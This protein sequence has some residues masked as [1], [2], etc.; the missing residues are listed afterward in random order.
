MALA[1]PS[2]T[3]LLSVLGHAAELMQ[4]ACRMEHYPD[5]PNA[6]DRILGFGSVP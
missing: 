1:L 4:M 6:R 5:S 3:R 2:L